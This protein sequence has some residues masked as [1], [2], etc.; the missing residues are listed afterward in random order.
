MYFCGRFE[1]NKK[2]EKETLTVDPDSTSL[3]TLHDADA[4]V[5][6]I[7]VD[8]RG[9]TVSGLI[10]ELDGLLLGGELGNGADGAENLLLHNL[11]VRLDVAEDGRL[12]KVSLVTVALTTNLNSGTLLLAGLDVVHDAV[13]LDLADLR[14]LERLGIEGVTNLVGR[15]ALLE[16]LEELVV[17]VLLDKDT[18][19]GAA[20]LAVVEVDAKVDPRNGLLNV[21]VVKDNVGRLAT[22]LE[23]NLLQVGGSGSLHDGAT[24]NGGAS[25]GNLVNVHVRGNGGTSSLAKAGK[26]VEDTSREAG[27]LDELGENEGGEGSLLSSLHD[28]TVTGSQGRANLPGEHEQGEVPGDNLAADADLM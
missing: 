28:D 20:A 18:G 7:G 4:T 1:P 26:Q 2:T 13:I 10:A 15:G 23:C 12:D 11:H 8:S 27:L 16:C 5:E 21:G 3:E 22:E 19:T 9:K 24:N 17:D 25:K 6:V 14:T